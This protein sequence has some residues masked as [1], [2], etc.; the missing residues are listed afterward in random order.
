MNKKIIL[1]YGEILWDLL[2]TAT[3]LGG[4]P[5]NFAYRINSLGNDGLFV[6][7]LGS[8]ELG[9]KAYQEM[10]ALGISPALLQWD[11][12]FPTGTVQVRFDENHNP[13]YVIIPSVAY[14][15]IEMNAQLTQVAISADCICFGTL[16]QRC[17][18]SRAT[19]EQVLQHANHSLKFLDI[20]L[21]KLCYTKASILT[22]LEAADILK[23]NEA[24][25]R[26]LAEILDFPNV[27]LTDFCQKIIDQWN[28]K[29]CLITLAD[30][31]VFAASA[32]GVQIYV[33]GHKIQLVD[34]LGAGDAFSAGFIH[35][36]LRGTILAEAC[37]F[38]NILGALAA[39]KLGATA[40]ISQ[41]EI[42]NFMNYQTGRNI[43]PEFE[44]FVL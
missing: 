16:I 1:S 32:D 11:D 42:D 10:I 7:R 8:D 3:V 43:K 6:S 2:P 19:L 38:G 41:T 22:S 39:S 30:Y 27:T 25:A 37:G 12:Q 34:S 21:R 33:P 5:F 29:Y 23:L 36:I 13:D 17:E 26:D 9:K 24:E 35:K 31:G 20:N 14:D 18:K 28:L 40:T 4:A 44:R 15:Q